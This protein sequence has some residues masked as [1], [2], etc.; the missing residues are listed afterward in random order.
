MV[1]IINNSAIFKAFGAFLLCLTAITLSHWPLLNLPFFWDEAGYYVPA[2]WDLYSAGS[3]IPTSVVAEAHPPLIPIY[4]AISWTMFGVT[5]IVARL[6][7][8][9]WSAMALL[10]AYL[11][12][13]RLTGPV[14]AVAS[15]VLL[16]AYPIFFVQS[17]LVQLDMPVTTLSIWACWAILNDRSS[18]AYFLLACAALTK[19]TGFLTGVGLAI[20]VLVADPISRALL[21]KARNLVFIPVLCFG[22]WLIVHWYLS[23]SI[24]GGSNFVEYNLLS[25][26]TSPKRLA[27]AA[28]LRLWHLTGHVG[29]W[30]LVLPS[31]VIVWV[32]RKRICMKAEPLGRAALLVACVGGIYLGA[33]TVIGG[34]VLARYMLPA[35]A[36]LIIFLGC[37]ASTLLSRKFIGL[38]F[39]LAL[40]AFTTGLF[41]QPP[42]HTA[43]EDTLM[44]ADFIKLHQQAIAMA[45]QKYPGQ[46]FVT[47]WPATDELT[48]PYLGYVKQPLPIKQIAD[49]N[50]NAAGNAIASCQGECVV[51]AFDTQYEPSDSW[52]RPS[53]LLPVWKKA[54][55]AIITRPGI[56]PEMIAHQNHLHLESALRKSP[57]FV[58]FLKKE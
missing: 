13:R 31:V 46:S 56:T 37:A 40:A 35:T 43:F 49:F 34:A 11:F 10:G 26:I 1:A 55:E 27:A 50:S 12:A 29:L 17:T 32:N 52:M 5:P 19:G 36:L 57:H 21:A 39:L 9:L 8:V 30:G 23:G 7:M 41:T 16:A 54:A 48:K 45:E 18:L 15:T 33:F 47:S 3:L 14:G 38:V 42:Y 2:A 22:G 58:A 44:Y 53:R 24:F 6:A 51:L 25:L 28:V 20:F 4:V